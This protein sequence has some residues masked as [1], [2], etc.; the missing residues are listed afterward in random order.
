[1]SLYGRLFARIYDRMM[2]GS[3]A[4]GLRADRAS[5]LAA[6]SG[7][8]LE[9]GAGT[10][11]NLAC[12][13]P[14]AV[15]EIVVTDPEEPML[16]RLRPHA[17]ARRPPATAVAAPAERLPFAAA[18]FDTVVSTLTLCTVR[19]PHAA[20]AEAHRVL[21]P[22][23][24]LL[25]LEHVRAREERAARLQDRITPLWRR[26]GHGCHPNRDTVA[27]IEAAGLDVQSV[28]YKPFPKGPRV[29]QPLACGIAV[30]PADA[31]RAA[32]P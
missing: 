2:A 23:G 8:V 10:G 18:S 3:E 28:D 20:L 7:R 6:A 4:A 25:F 21:V 5:L 31:A 22:G 17:A 12:Y 24:R 9:I 27:A 29:V 26:I 16:R 15:T 30:K 32:G 13:D 19:D 1:V 14:D 11:A